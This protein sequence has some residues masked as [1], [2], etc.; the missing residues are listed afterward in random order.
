MIRVITFCPNHTALRLGASEW[1]TWGE[2]FEMLILDVS[3]QRIAVPEVKGKVVTLVM[4]Q[5]TM[6]VLR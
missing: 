5:A 6:Q 4:V 1:N 3:R 2:M